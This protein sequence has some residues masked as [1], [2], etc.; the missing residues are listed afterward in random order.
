MEVGRRHWNQSIWPPS[1]RAS[2][3][4]RR[5]LVSRTFALLDRRIEGPRQSSLLAVGPSQ[6]GCAFARVK[7]R[8]RSA[9]DNKID[10]STTRLLALSLASFA[11]NCQRKQNGCDFYSN[12][13]PRE[14][15]AQADPQ[16]LPKQTGCLARHQ[17]QIGAGGPPKAIQPM[18]LLR[19]SC[20][21]H[22]NRATDRRRELSQFASTKRS[23]SVRS[24]DCIASSR[25]F[26]PM[27]ARRLA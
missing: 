11:G 5:S 20:I 23:I 2:L 12:L 8:T 18:D 7:A 22:R 4:R 25:A 24:S 9:S 10:L 3:R 19:A 14:V 1:W 21:E 27:P 6:S 13:A 17:H 16:K 26:P 15:R